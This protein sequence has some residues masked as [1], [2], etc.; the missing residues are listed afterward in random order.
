VWPA[1]ALGAPLFVGPAATAV[2]GDPFALPAGSRVVGWALIAAF[3]LWNGWGYGLMIR[4]ETGV[5]PGR[6]TRRVLDHGPFRVSRNPLYLGV[7]AL[8]VGIALLLPSTW[9][10]L[11]VPAAA[12]LITWGAIVPEERYLAAKFGEEYL[13]YTRRVRRWL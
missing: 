6:A 1:V 13:A 11:L 2:I 12:G 4:H 7:I 9:M 10:L 5:L 8:D 3:A